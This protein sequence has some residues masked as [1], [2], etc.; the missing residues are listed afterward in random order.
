MIAIRCDGRWKY[1][2]HVTKPTLVYHADWSSSASKRWCA[3]ATLGAD[4]HYT[5]LELANVGELKSLLTG[6]RH[7]AG[8]SGIVFAGF[9]F[10]IGV[11]A[12]FAERA[13]VGKFRDLLPELG[14]GEW[15]DFYSAC[16]TRG[17]I[18]IH[19]PF[20]PNKSNTGC[21]PQ[22]LL[23]A[24]K[25]E[26]MRDLLRT[27][28][29]GGSGQRQAC[30]LFWTLGG[31][32]VG[33]AALN[34][35]RD[36]LVP[37]IADQSLRVWPFD[38]PLE[39]LLKPGLTVIAETYPAECYGWFPDTPSVSKRDIN[40]RIEFGTILLAWA[41][42]S[43]VA[44]EPRLRTAIEA[45]FPIGRDDAFDAVVGLF[46]MLQVC[47]GQRDSGEPQDETIRNVEGWILGRQSR[48]VERPQTVYSA[49]NDPELA[50]W[51]RWACESGEASCFIHAIAEAVV[52]ADLPHY[53]MLRPVL[54]EL[55][56][57][58]PEIDGGRLAVLNRRRD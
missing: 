2:P 31:N 36:V 48:P 57:E 39:S 37:A 58:Y 45:G 33:K 52:I 41:D 16:D 38:G 21:I 26:T 28:E 11:P 3:V 54:L 24:Y 51:I 55:K 46:G 10:P 44:I 8:E 12:H 20:Y 18:S 53:T 43:E 50:D 34:G 7:T 27:C 35:W 56:R 15:R 19:R 47:V 49:A 1:N 9:D 14:K 17:Q 23:A 4:E 22:H 42:S 29:R 40:S 5:A 6:L 32:Q 30:S 25:A 13:G